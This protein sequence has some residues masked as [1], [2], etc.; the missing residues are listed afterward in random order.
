ME[1]LNRRRFLKVA[2]ASSAVAAGS[3]LPSIG[4]LA[5]NTAKN[6]TVTFRA[7][8]GM[9]KEP[10]PNYASYVI[11]GHVNLDSN[12]GV[13]TKSVFAGAPEAMSTIAL[14]GMSRIARITNVVEQ[15]GVL[16]ITGVVDDRSQLGRG[17]SPTFTVLIDRSLG[18][19]KA[20]FFGD[21]V[22]LMLER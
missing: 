15:A 12:S 11:E 20:D 16:R 8:A 19:A 21:S 5:D 18:T 9:P 2:G 13:I 17:E 1:K 4:L 3:A 22:T 7:V 14:P 10:L 6:G